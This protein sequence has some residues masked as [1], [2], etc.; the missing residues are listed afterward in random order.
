[1]FF[2]VFAD[3]RILWMNQFES[4][5]KLAAKEQWCWNLACTTCGHEVF[6]SAM[7]DLAGGLDPES[8]AWTVHRASLQPTVATRRPAQPLGDWPHDEQALLQQTAVGCDLDVISRLAAFPDWLGYIGILLRYTEQAEASNRLLTR[9]FVPQL[10][11][12]VRPNSRGLELL[13]EIE[14]GSRPL[15]WTDLETIESSC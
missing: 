15:R 11:K 6:R 8:A 12:F 14:R 10:I 13:R 5:C 7:R 2:H 9:A 3:I 1:M 4:L